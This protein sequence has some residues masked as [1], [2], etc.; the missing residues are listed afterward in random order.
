MRL[1][2]LV[3]VTGALAL[4]ACAKPDK[5]DG[6]DNGYC[7]Q[8]TIDA[9][10]NIV[11]KT[12][13]KADT[14]GTIATSC[15][16]I[17]DL[18]QGRSCKAQSLMSGEEKSISYTNVQSICESKTK[19]TSAKKSMTYVDEDGNCTKAF[20]EDAREVAKTLD[21]AVK[22]KSKVLAET[23][24][25]KCED[26]RVELDGRSCKLYDKE[27]QEH[28]R[29]STTEGPLGQL[30]DGAMKLSKRLNE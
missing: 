2:V 13:A 22:T 4:S 19:S 23:A 6:V 7:T 27:K 30:C 20:M 10:N 5:D 25:W 9:Y 16:S 1:G 17:Q 24:F 21:E 28:T 14:D 29:H 15:K 11:S 12:F 8:A 26:I 3:L 18:L